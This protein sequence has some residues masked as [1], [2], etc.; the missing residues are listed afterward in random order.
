MPWAWA[1]AMSGDGDEADEAIVR[2][3]L[4]ANDRTVWRII[5]DWTAA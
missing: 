2:T 3:A 4:V 1:M 5:L